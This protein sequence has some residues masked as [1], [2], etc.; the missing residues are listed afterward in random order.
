MGASSAL[1]RFRLMSEVR[2]STDSSESSAPMTEMAEKM[3]GFSEMAG[4]SCSCD[5]QTDV[6]LCVGAAAAWG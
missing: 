6:L 5:G 4:F 2:T 1:V 3:A